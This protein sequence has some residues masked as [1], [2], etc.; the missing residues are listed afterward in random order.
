THDLGV[1]AEVADHVLV[2]Y[3]G[4]AVEYG[5][6]KQLLSAPAMPYTLGLIQSVPELDSDV[7]EPLRP[8][9]GNPP[10]L[11][12]APPG[13]AFAPRCT[14][15]HLVPDNLPDTVMPELVE[16]APGHLRRCHLEEHDLSKLTPVPIGGVA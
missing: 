8:I 15:K 5:T 4:R 3:A 2:M 9:P 10:S 13:C 16:I 14:F 11:L 1:I 6:T 7:S 12:D